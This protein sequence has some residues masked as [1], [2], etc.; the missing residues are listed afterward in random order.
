MVNGPWQIPTIKRR[1][2][3]ARVEGLDAP[4]GPDQ[5]LDP[6]RR[7]HR[8]HQGLQERRRGLGVHHAGPRS[9]RTSPPTSSPR[10][11]S[12]RARR[13]PSRRNGPSDAAVKVFVEQLASARPRAYGPKYPE[14]SAAVQDMLQSALTGD[15]IDRRGGQDRGRQGRAA[16]ARPEPMTVVSV[17]ASGAPGA[18]AAAAVAA[19]GRAV[20]LRRARAAVPARARA[21]PDR[22]QHP[23]QP[24]RPQRRHLPGRRSPLRRARQLLEGALNDEAFRH[25][26][27]VSAVFTVACIVLQFTLGLALALFFARPFPGSGVLQRAAGPRLAAARRGHRQPLPLA[28]RRRLAASCRG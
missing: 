25:A 28:A 15:A 20:P 2:A 26:V 14:I 21:L 24:D 13:S 8:R 19:Q 22:L 6:R 18:P 9:R 5:R 4:A 11:R 10:A 23:Q 16:A 3:E 12:L 7:E 1:Q 17:E 27:G